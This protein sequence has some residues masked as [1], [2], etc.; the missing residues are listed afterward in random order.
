MARPTDRRLDHGLYM[1]LR[2]V[3]KVV[4]KL[5]LPNELPSVH[6]FFHISKLRKFIGDPTSIVSLEALEVKE[7]LSY[8][9]IPIE[10]LNRQVNKLRNQKVASV[11][12]LWRNHLVKGTTWE[13][14]A[15]MLSRYPHLFPFTPTLA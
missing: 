14:E 5:D 1:I 12:V 10:V 7:N 3:G 2:R 4:Y 13:A 8:E 6:S 15:D 11:K 9:D